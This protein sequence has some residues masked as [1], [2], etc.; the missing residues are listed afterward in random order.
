MPMKLNNNKKKQGVVNLNEAR[1]AS[2]K[3]RPSVSADKKI[4][5]NNLQNSK[6]ENSLPTINKKEKNNTSINNIKIVRGENDKKFFDRDQNGKLLITRRTLIYGA[7]GAGAIVAGSAGIK[8]ATDTISNNN[9]SIET[10]SVGKNDVINSDSLTE[11]PNQFLSVD[12]EI[13]LPYGT[14]AFANSSNVIACLIPTDKAK[15]LSVVDLININSGKRIE[16]LTESVG[17]KEGYE[18]YDVRA[19]DEGIVWTEVNILQGEWR[20]Y[21]STFSDGYDI[22]PI[23]VDKGGQDW[24]TPTITITNQAAYWQV[25]PIAG[26]GKAS[27]NSSLKKINLKSIVSDETNMTSR[28][29]SNSQISNCPN[30]VYVSEGR[31]SSPVYAY[32]DGVVITPRAKSGNIFYTLTY[33]DANNHVVDSVSLPQNMKPLEAGY[34]ATGFNFC[35]DAIYNY[36][37]GIS[38]LGYY[39]P[40]TK[41]KDSYNNLKWLNFSRNPSA[42]PAWFNNLF[43]VRSTMAVCV[44]NLENQSYCVLDRPNA[45]DDYGDYL[46]STGNCSKIVTYANV[47]DQPVAGEESKYCSLR[48]WS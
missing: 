43:V 6:K 30:T 38:N 27:L 11:S 26:K 10:L 24:E 36:G 18:I 12:R 45:S 23:L 37:D 40:I 44:V 3:K 14:L 32:N 21:V 1:L 19:N 39:A 47:H 17:Q 13:E 2:N 28:Y 29:E 34:G 41:N 31:M 15:P 35:F 20:I 7:I 46:A 33:I 9:S 8:F 48:I 22:N 5:H 4:S 16:A 42:A 25:M